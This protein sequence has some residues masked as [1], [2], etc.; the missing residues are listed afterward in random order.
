MRL[1]FLLCI[2]ILLGSQ[3]GF[4]QITIDESYITDMIGQ[5]RTLIL[6]DTENTAGLAGILGANGANQNWDFNLT[7]QDTTLFMET[8]LPVSD[9]IPAATNPLFTDANFVRLG[10]I[11]PDPPDIPDTSRVWIFQQL[12]S[13][14]LYTLGQS[15]LFD[16]DNDGALDTLIQFFD[17][18]SLNIVF[19]VEF[20][21]QWSDSTTF[22]SIF[23]GMNFPTLTQTSTTNITGWGTIS[24]QFGNSSVLRHERVTRSTIPMSGI[25]TE[26]SDIEFSGLDG[27]S[28]EIDLDPTGAPERAT[29]ICVASPSSR[30]G[31]FNCA[32]S[33]TSI[34]QE[35]PDAR[36][37]DL[38]QNYPNPF[39]QS[40]TFTY[41]V[42]QT[43]H[44][45]LV[46]Y[47]MLGQEVTTLVDRDQP[48]GE[49]LVGW[50]RKGDNGR[51]APP[52]RY[53]YQL[54]LD[55]QAHTTKDLVISH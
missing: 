44:V 39:N 27:I 20:G 48:T 4:A 19:P 51:L 33:T 16:V 14:M 35:N 41:T 40:T 5:T 37:S 32:T 53:F 22:V 34:E 18:P 43:G 47:N 8:I 11:P 29:V 49:H 55:G 3:P 28:A 23:A 2:L 26:D 1:T 25:V 36:A 13:G 7:W 54:I 46:V 31:K 15:S 6:Y 45:K 38:A 17:P 9:D 42:K 10:V 52:G 21:N 30:L 50:N 12:D 24:T